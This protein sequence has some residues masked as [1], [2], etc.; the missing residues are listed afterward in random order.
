MF[1]LI[2]SIDRVYVIGRQNIYQFYA[3]LEIHYYFILQ[4]SSIA[5]FFTK[6]ILT[7][8]ILVSIW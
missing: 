1:F 8:N 5:L 4:M 7:V 6:Y 3:F 2:C